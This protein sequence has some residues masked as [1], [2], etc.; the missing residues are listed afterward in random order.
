[1]Y[2]KMVCLCR[3]TVFVRML[4]VVADSRAED[5]QFV[6]ARARAAGWPMADR[7]LPAQIGQHG[8][9]LPELCFGFH[10]GVA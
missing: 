7:G 5:Q 6:P 10:P 2:G 4:W 8:S 1:M 9:F 3:S